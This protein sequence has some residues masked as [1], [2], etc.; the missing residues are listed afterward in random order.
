MG[1][2][3]SGEDRGEQRFSWLSSTYESVA[4]ESAVTGSF[5]DATNIGV[6]YASIVKWS[7]L[8]YGISDQLWAV[9]A[10]DV[11]AI[12]PFPEQLLNAPEAQLRLDEMQELTS[13][14]RFV[15][16]VATWSP[17]V[18]RAFAG[19]AG[20]RALHR[21]SQALEDGLRTIGPAAEDGD[22]GLTD[23]QL[24]AH[25]R[26]FALVRDMS[27]SWLRAVGGA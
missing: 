10:S 3:L 15:A 26:S 6:A 19:E 20:G 18:A 2:T 7:G 16:K 8:P 17:G 25:E 21:L 13:R 23:S 12:T 22:W 5:V 27:S 9:E 1:R 11:V 4:S 14:V 24:D